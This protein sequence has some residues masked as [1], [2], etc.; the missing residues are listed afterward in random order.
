MRCPE[1]GK[2]NRPDNVYCVRCDAALKS[3]D[4]VKPVRHGEV[5]TRYKKFVPQSIVILIC[6]LAG[7]VLTYYLSRLQLPE[8]VGGAVPQPEIQAGGNMLP[9][10]AQLVSWEG[11]TIEAVG[12]T[13]SEEGLTLYYSAKNR[14]D[15]TIACGDPQTEADGFPLK[16]LMYLELGPGEE[17]TDSILIETESLRSAGTREIQDLKLCFELVH[18]ADFTILAQPDPVT[19]WLNLEL[20]G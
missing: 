2:R 11:F 20:P 17:T 19:I 3:R 6:M 14:S 5:N 15:Q 10:E 9:L 7:L 16:S 18:A 13:P 8:T 1:C 4:E 12:F